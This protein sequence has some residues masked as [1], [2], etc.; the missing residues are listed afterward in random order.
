[1][2][3]PMCDE[4]I[5]IPRAKRIYILDC[6]HQGPQ[7]ITKCRARARTS[8]W[9]SGLSTLI[10]Q[11]VSKCV[12]CAKYRPVPTEPLMDSSF[13]S[14]SWER[15]NC[16][17]LVRNAWQTLS[18]RNRHVYVLNDVFASHGI[19]D[20][21]ISDNGPQFSAATFRQFAVNYSFVNVTSSPRYP[22][23]NGEAERTMKGMLINTSVSWYT[24]RRRFRMA[25]LQQKCSWADDFALNYPSSR[26]L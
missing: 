12:T 3:F 19:P 4:R 15:L 1:M 7:G 18:H 9:W 6:I 23:S 5:V 26:A 2:T 22:Q 11:M 10:E 17:G 20:I 8:V 14:R 13:P 25:Y 16:D 24:D 21:I